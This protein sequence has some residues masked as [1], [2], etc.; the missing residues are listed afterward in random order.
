MELEPYR[1]SFTVESLPI[2]IM[3][4]ILSY[5]SYDEISVYRRVSRHFNGCCQRLLNQGFF[6]AE[7]FHAQCL[8]AVKKQLPRRESERRTHP[9]ARH[10][11]ILTSIE[12]RLSLLSMTFMKYMDMNLCCFIPG[13]VIDEIFRVLRLVQGAGHGCTT[14]PPRAHEILQELRDISSMAMEHFDERIAPGLKL[15]VGPMKPTLGFIGAGHHGP[16]AITAT[17]PRSSELATAT[18]ILGRVQKPCVHAAAHL[19]LTE[20]IKQVRAANLSLRKSLTECKSKLTAQSKKQCE[21][22]KRAHDQA[23]L[24][25]EQG[26][27]LAEQEGKLNELNR[28]LLE[29][30]REFADVL[31][32][33]SR[34]REQVASSSSNGV[35]GI[36]EPDQ[37]DGAEMLQKT[38]R[39]RC[40]RKGSNAP[41]ETTVSSSKRRNADG[42]LPDIEPSRKRQCKDKVATEVE[43]PRRTGMATR[44]RPVKC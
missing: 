44:S 43:R 26:S 36:G 16:C 27:R 25:A 18:S 32:E 13:K 22:E 15:H 24:I 37:S 1:R 7:R 38:M 34:L 2:E 10:C 9:L 21:Q 12:T 17:V 4:H 42:A 28:K 33:V 23:Q 29:Q 3:D 20:E 6:R 8:K 5:L 19:S 31:E 40:G 39:P 30:H 14:T 41:R 35:S 11:E